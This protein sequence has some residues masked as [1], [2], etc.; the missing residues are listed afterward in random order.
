MMYISHVIGKIMYYYI[1]YLRLESGKDLSCIN[2]N[3]TQ[4]ILLLHVGP[5][6]TK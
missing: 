3:K 4:N 6:L 2:M 1:W 5:K